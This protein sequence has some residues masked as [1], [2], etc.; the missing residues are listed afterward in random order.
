[1]ID[2]MGLISPEAGA[3]MKRTNQRTTSVPWTAARYDVDCFVLTGSPRGEWP[4]VLDGATGYRLAHTFTH[5]PSQS[6]LAI[7]SR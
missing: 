3:E 4:R 1:M 2:R 5:G 7:Y 6:L